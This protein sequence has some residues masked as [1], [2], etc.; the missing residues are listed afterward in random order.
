MTLFFKVMKYGSKIQI[1][2]SQTCLNRT[3]NKQESYINQ[4]ENSP[5]VGNLS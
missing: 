5:N 2:Y 4:T 3:L 1:K